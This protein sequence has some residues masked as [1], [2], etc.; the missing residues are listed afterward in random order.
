MSVTHSKIPCD[1]MYMEDVEQTN[2]ETQ[3]R[4]MVF[5]GWRVRAVDFLVNGQSFFGG[6]GQ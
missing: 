6:R 4:K 3:R 2:S 1:F 5:K